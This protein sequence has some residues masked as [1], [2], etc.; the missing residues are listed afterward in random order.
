MNYFCTPTLTSTLTYCKPAL[1]HMFPTSDL[2]RVDQS[3]EMS[4][5]SFFRCLHIIWTNKNIAKIYV[6]T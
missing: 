1:K 2:K 5:K 3:K 6:C 4:K